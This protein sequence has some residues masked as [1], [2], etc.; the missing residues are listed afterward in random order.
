MIITCLSQTQTP[1][2]HHN[3]CIARDQHVTKVPLKCHK[4]VTGLS[5]ARRT[6]PR[7]V[8]PVFS[9]FQRPLCAAGY[10]ISSTGQ[11]EPGRSSCDPRAALTRHVPPLLGDGARWI[12]QRERESSRQESRNGSDSFT[13]HRSVISGL[14][15]DTPVLHEL[16]T[17]YEKS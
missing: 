13:P 15:R 12:T 8:G 6:P 10:L 16:L 7:Q 4:R 11:L 1:A 9:Q 3:S 5:A 17:F 2:P 14:L